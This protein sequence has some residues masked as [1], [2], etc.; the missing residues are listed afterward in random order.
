[1]RGNEHTW[2]GKYLFTIDFVGDGFSR[3]P[4]HWK[5]LHVIETLNGYFVLYPQYRIQFTD[6]ALLGEEKLPVYKANTKHW[7]VGS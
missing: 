3:H 7:I 4:E 6:K 1:V 5:Q 2:T